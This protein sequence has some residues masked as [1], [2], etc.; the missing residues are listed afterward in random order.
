M[1]L[2]GSA[3]RAVVTLFVGVGWAACAT[4]QTYGGPTILRYGQDI[5]I[6]YLQTVPGPDVYENPSDPDFPY[7]MPP[8]GAYSGPGYFYGGNPYGSGPSGFPYGMPPYAYVP[9][10]YP[11]GPYGYGYPPPYPSPGYPS[12]YSYP[13]YIEQSRQR[14]IYRTMTLRE[15]I[16]RELRGPTRVR[17]I[18]PGIPELSN[19]PMSRAR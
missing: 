18:V 13:N 10:P 19:G 1:T 2:R 9:N 14:G 11:Y 16:A 15:Y 5:G 4:A 6:P 3:G 7:V 12:D 17:D 8:P